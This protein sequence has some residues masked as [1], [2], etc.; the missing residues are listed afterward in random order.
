[1]TGDL[2]GLLV[3]RLLEMTHNSSLGAAVLPAQDD[4]PDENGKVPPE[5]GSFYVPNVYVLALAKQHP[6]FLPAVSIHPARPDV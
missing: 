3:A 2:D 1:M 4:V 5:V 6:K